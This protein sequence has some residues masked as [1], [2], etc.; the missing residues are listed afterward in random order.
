MTR[1]QVVVTV[2]PHADFLEEVAGH[3]LVGGL[4]LNTVMPLKGTIHD[5]LQRL[6]GLGQPLWVD[7]KGRQ[8]RVAEPALP[9]FTAVRLSHRIEVDTPTTAL[10]GNGEEAVRV[11]AVDGDRLILEDGPRRILGPG[12]SVNIVDP[13][14]VIHGRLTAQDEAYLHAMAELGLRRVMMSFAEEE[15]DLEAVRALLP[16][17]ELVAKIESQ[18]GLRFAP[19]ADARLMAARGD[20]FLELERPHH[21]LRALR[22][23]LAVDPHTLVA[24]RIC[25]SLA[26]QDEPTCADISDIACLLGLGCR[27]LMLGDEVCMRRDSVIAA[28]NLI[29]CVGK[30]TPGVR[31]RA[32]TLVGAPLG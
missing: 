32:R 27:T 8:L 6:A 22:A 17:A 29:E 2:P 4:R 26:W 19:R 21:V 3:P 25:D 16:E 9:P 7:L 30:D 31:V 5:T 23:L 1:L 28:L 14:L 11:L 10:F 12:E 13:S 24:S 20:L 18:K 15:E